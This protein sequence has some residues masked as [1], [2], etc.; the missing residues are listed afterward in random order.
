MAKSLGSG[1]LCQQPADFACRLE[2]PV[3]CT[4]KW[5]EPWDLTAPVTPHGFCCFVLATR[6]LLQPEGP[7]GAWVMGGR[8][9]RAPGQ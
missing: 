4:M 7:H 8:G 1:F 3:Y 9:P 2:Q 5:E 6:A